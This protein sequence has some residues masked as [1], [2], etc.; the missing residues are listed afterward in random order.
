MFVTNPKVTDPTMAG[1][2][3][4]WPV[5]FEND[6][7]R[8]RLDSDINTKERTVTT[9]TSGAIKTEPDANDNDWRPSF[10]G[11]SAFGTNDATSQNSGE[12]Q[13]THRISEG[14][15]WAERQMESMGFKA[16]QGLGKVG[17]GIIA[18]IKESDQAGRRGLGFKVEGLERETVDDQEIEQVEVRQVPEWFPKCTASIPTESDIDTWMEIGDKSTI[19]IPDLIFDGATIFD[20]LISAKSLLD[21]VSRKEFLPARNRSNPFEEIRKEFF[22]NR[23]ALK[24][25]NIDA[26]FDFIFTNPE[27]TNERE[28]VYF[29]DICAGPGGF[30]EYVMWRKKW[31]AKGFGL[32][33]RDSQLDFKLYKFNSQSP[34]DTF[35]IHYGRDKSGDIYNQ[36]NMDSLRDVIFDQTN[37]KMLHFVSADGGMDFTQDQNNQELTNAQLLLCQVL[38]AFMILREGGVFVCKTFDLFTKFSV[39]LMYLMWLSFDQISIV[40]THTSRPANSERYVVG[41][42][43]H[44]Q[45]PIVP[46]LQKINGRLNEL[47]RSNAGRVK[48]QDVVGLVPRNLVDL[49]FLDFLNDSCLKLARKQVRS[50]KKLHNF[51]K[52]PNLPGENQSQIRI[53][54]LKEWKVPDHGIIREE[55]IPYAEDFYEHSSFI[56]FFEDDQNQ[57]KNSPDIRNQP[58]ALSRDHVEDGTTCKISKPSD[59]V[60]A[61]LP[62]SLKQQPSQRVYIMSLSDHRSYRT[63][64]HNS[65]CTW[66]EVPGLILPP[67]TFLVGNLVLE[68]NAA[69][70]RRNLAL[71]IL[72]AMLL[73][74]E[75]VRKLPFE[76]RSVQIELFVKAL[77]RHPHVES[78]PLNIGRD[79]PV[80]VRQS[81]WWRFA[82]QELPLALDLIR[83]GVDSNEKDSC[84]WDIAGLYLFPISNRTP[85]N[86]AWKLDESTGVFHWYDMSSGERTMHEFR[87]RAPLSF[88]TTTSMHLEWVAGR[89][90]ITEADLSRLVAS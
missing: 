70:D 18:P 53:D 12:N 6:S 73:G 39:D 55:R 56:H 63:P 32:T 41:K 43:Y 87:D 7:K 34:W 8:K 24:M 45:S 4:S 37:G 62:V 54:C 19:V 57:D 49:K 3:R 22:Q 77:E 26:V 82:Q 10:G 90:A 58:R 25:A 72:D 47:K 68:N 20:E 35:H 59:W 16:G 21:N 60:I 84:F 14:K 86:F 29:A 42:G 30:S 67:K 13:S 65:R 76:E 2:K 80:T 83:G 88:R 81:K 31:R 27:N 71:H 15:S 74:G 66:E 9:D 38:C 1:L 52:D 79:L 78:F 46:Y 51:I 40:K 11:G 28:L 69:L 17:Q 61:A 64:P 33:L 23:A 48:V 5:D 50:L 36:D 89:S 75:D 44:G 85:K